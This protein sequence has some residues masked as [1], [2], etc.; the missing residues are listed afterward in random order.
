MFGYVRP[1]RG[2]LKVWELEAYEAAYCGLCHALGRRYGFFSRFFLSYDLTF[3]A[4]LLAP[5]EE[6]PTLEYR[7]C[8]ACPHRKK[9]VCVSSQGMETAADESVILTYWKLRD[10]AQDGKG[11][12]KLGAKIL[13]RLCRGGYRRAAA[14][15]P[16]FD[17]CVRESLEQ[18]RTLE[19]E[20]CTSL[21]RTADTFARILRSAA[22][23]SGVT[24][25]D[26]SRGELLYHLGRWI[27][28]VDAWDDLDD[29]KAQGNYNPI[30]ARFQGREQEERQYLRTTLR[31]SL[32]LARSAFGLLDTGCWS[33]P[34]GNILDLGLPA[35]EELVFRGEWKAAEHRF[36]PRHP[37]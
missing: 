19:Q 32:N 34:I 26:R 13:A 10:E 8:V 4:M 22:P 2:E 15:K 28:L 29:D 18:L 11:V 31:H 35:V 12:K 23:E 30:H 20:G 3:L 37:Q 9:G 5:K 36:F 24:A 1:Y 27:Y 21:D 6:R 33:G 7:R 17:R 14:A 16:D 25:V